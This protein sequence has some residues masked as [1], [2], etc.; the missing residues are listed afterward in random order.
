MHLVDRA[1]SHINDNFRRPFSDRVLR[2][3][4]A[5][6]LPNPR[7]FRLVLAGGKLAKFFKPL[8]APKYLQSPIV[9]A[10]KNTSSFKYRLGWHY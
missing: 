7:L 8:S 2:T 5:L 10:D 1:R 9:S 3:F 4:L 6:V